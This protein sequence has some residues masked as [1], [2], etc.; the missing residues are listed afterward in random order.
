MT[1]KSLRNRHLFLADILSVVLATLIAFIVRFEHFQWLTENV[2]LV[3]TYMVLTVPLRLGVFY[4]SGMYRRLWRH[5][6]V[7]ELKPIIMAAAVGGLVC[8][9]VGLIFLP[10]TG[11]TALQTVRRSGLGVDVATPGA[12]TAGLAAVKEN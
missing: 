10:L 7:G 8:A 2:K 6:S 4:A 1:L 9:A 11:L 12:V 3:G 5:A